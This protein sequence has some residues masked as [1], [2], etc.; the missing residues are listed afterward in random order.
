MIEQ[1]LETWNK[2]LPQSVAEILRSLYVDDL[3]SGGPTVTRA[4]KLK[5]DAVTI[6]SEGGFQLHKWHSHSPEL[7]KSCQENLDL[8]EVTYAKQN[9]LIVEQDFSV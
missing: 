2:Q 4:K 5:A 1:H 7:E 8:S 9:L 6:F 3:L